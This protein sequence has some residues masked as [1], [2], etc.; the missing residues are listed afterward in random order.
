MKTKI[1]YGIW[2]AVLA[3][4]IGGMLSGCGNDGDGGSKLVN[5]NPGENDLN[6][7]VAFG[8][9]ITGGVGEGIDPYPPRLAALIGKT[10]HNEGIGGSKAIENVG[11]AQTVISRHKP[12]YMLILYGYNDII[13]GRRTSTVVSSVEEMTVICEQNNVVPV[14]ATYPIPILGHRVFAY[15]VWLLNEGIR[16]MAKARGIE[17]VD[18]EREFSSGRKEYETSDWDIPDPALYMSDGLHPSNA[19]ADVIAAAFADLF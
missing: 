11:R 10:V 3:V 14:V 9:S 8:D 1:A 13:N 2:C 15:G 12:A 16:S 4:A 7:V 17:C 5:R 6:V 18:L 19:G